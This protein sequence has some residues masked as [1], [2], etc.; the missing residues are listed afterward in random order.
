MGH[1]GYVKDDVESSQYASS[2]MEAIPISHPESGR[3]SSLIQGGEA[4]FLSG[5][6]Y[7]APLPSEQGS[8]KFSIKGHWMMY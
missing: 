8:L 7:L 2:I 5:Q 3:N 1:L 4:I 6:R